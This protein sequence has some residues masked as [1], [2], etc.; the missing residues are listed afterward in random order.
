MDQ[1]RSVKSPDLE[2]PAAETTCDKLMPVLIPHP[3]ALLRE[4]VDKTGNEVDPGKK[5]GVGEGVLLL[6]LLFIIVLL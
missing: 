1:E 4:K 2:E 5:R 3:P 6:L